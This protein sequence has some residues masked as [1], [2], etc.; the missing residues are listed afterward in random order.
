MILRLTRKADV[1]AEM[2]YEYTWITPYEDDTFAYRQAADFA[3]R[4]SNYHGKSFNVPSLCTHC[5]A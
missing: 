3:Q 1:Y 2:S 5:D 4:M